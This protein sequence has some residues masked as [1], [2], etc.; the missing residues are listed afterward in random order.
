[1]NLKSPDISDWNAKMQAVARHGDREAFGEL[2]L[3]FAPRVKAYLQKLGAGPAAEELTQEAMLTVWRKAPLFDRQK[4]SAGTWIFTI[5]RNL[6]VDALRRERRPEFGYDDPALSAPM[7]TQVDIS[8]ANQQ[9]EERVRQAMLQL[10]PEQAEIVRASFFSD[11]PHSQIAAEFNL[12]L[13]T[14]KSRLRLAM[15]RLRTALG[16]EP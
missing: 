12:P 6:R 15:N 1:M 5:A 10:P 11:K 9:A 2:F 13:G 14:V 8:L 3:H 7:E 4:A 16:D